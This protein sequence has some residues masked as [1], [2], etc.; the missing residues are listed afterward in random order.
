MSAPDIDQKFH[1]VCSL[2][3]E[4]EDM[5]SWP[6]GGGG[7]GVMRGCITGRPSWRDGAR[8]TCL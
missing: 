6:T 3:A 8:I 4:M 2:L 1:D 5:A 7:D